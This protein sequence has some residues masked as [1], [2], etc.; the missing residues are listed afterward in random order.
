VQP[1]YSDA[2][3]RCADI[4]TLAA[5]AGQ[6]GKWAAIRLSDGGYD[7]ALYD[8]RSDAVRHQLWE[9]QCAYVK[10]APGG[11]TAMEAEAFLDYNR[12]LYDA[13]FRMP[14]PDFAM[15]LMPLTAKDQKRQISVLAKGHI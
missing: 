2:A 10:V 12:K 5:I 11:M 15:P 8:L 14:D 9:K 13:G 1:G 7:N 4:I 6:V 3:K